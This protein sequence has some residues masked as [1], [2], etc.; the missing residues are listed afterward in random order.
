VRVTEGHQLSLPP[1]ARTTIPSCAKA[2]L[3]VASGSTTT[4]RPRGVE[5]VDNGA[6]ASPVMGAG[7]APSM[8]AAKVAFRSAWVQFYGRLTPRDI[9]HWHRHQDD[10]QERGEWLG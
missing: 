10:A 9:E 1:S 5:L 4:D 7:R 3:S 8:E 6:V 2:G